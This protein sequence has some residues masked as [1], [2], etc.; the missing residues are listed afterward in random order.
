[1]AALEIVARRGDPQFLNILLHELKHPT[2]VRVL[3]NMKRLKQVVWLEANH[4]QLLELDGRAQAVAVDLAMASGIKED[5][6]YEL[7][8]S[9]LSDGLSEGRRASCRALTQFEGAK[10][11]E[12]ALAALEDPDAGVE[13]AALRQLRPRRLPDAL[14]LLVG[15]LDAP[16]AEVREA[17]RS[18]LAE[19]NFVRY[20]SMFD[21]LDAEAART[22][23]LLVYKIDKDAM[24]QLREELASPSLTA[25]LRAIEMALAMAA[26]DDVEPQLVELA[27][28]ENAAVRK[29]ACLALGHCHGQRP[30]KVLEAATRDPNATVADAARQGFAALQRREADKKVCQLSN[31]PSPQPSPKGKGSE[32]KR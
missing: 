30:A 6:K 14:K 24:V 1:V 25:R 18:S 4:R 23:G 32:A 16:S 9:M 27:R 13:A 31:A 10:A 5:A 21:L 19:F 28:H 26:A 2:P 11:N 3:H 20:R 29:E 22:T 15:R 8:A 7:L 17:A 12:L